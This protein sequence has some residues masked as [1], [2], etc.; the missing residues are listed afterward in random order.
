[1]LLKKTGTG[2]QFRT[3]ADLE[4][5]I[6]EHLEAL[7]NLKPLGRQVSLAGGIADI[8]GVDPQGGL[9]I[10]ELKNESDRHIVQQLTRYYEVARKERPFSALVD[11]T[12]PISL[13]AVSN[14][15]HAF[16]WLDVRHHRLD[17]RFLQYAIVEGNTSLTLQLIEL[18]DEHKEEIISV[19]NVQRVEVTE[20]TFI[21]SPSRALLNLLAKCPEEKRLSGLLFRRILLEADPQMREIPS[22]GCIFYG[23]TKGQRCGELRLGNHNPTGEKLL[24]GYLWLPFSLESPRSGRMCL[25][26]WRGG[27]VEGFYHVPKG[28]QTG[29]SQSTW[30]IYEQISRQFSLD[31]QSLFPLDVL[32]KLAVDRWRHKR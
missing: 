16:N 22:G 31:E 19:L 27:F 23:S 6:W 28:L 29:R 15:F 18:E 1:M 14:E 24:L 20:S 9:V 13:V 12:R 32:A 30:K 21:G 25:L 5:V 7:L 8:L 26:G 4:D 11:Y 2:L 3:E 10:I 17:F